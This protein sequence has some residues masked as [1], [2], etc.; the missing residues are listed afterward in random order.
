MAGWGTVVAE[1]RPREPDVE[2]RRRRNQVRISEHELVSC[3]GLRSGIDVGASAVGI[4]AESEVVPPSP[5]PHHPVLVARAPV[6]AIVELCV[7]AAVAGISGVVVVQPGLVGLIPKVAQR[8][9]RGVLQRSRDRVV[10]KPGAREV[11]RAGHRERIV[12]GPPHLREIALLLQR[13]R[14]VEQQ[15]TAL[16]LAIALIGGEEENAVLD[17]RAADIGAP[18]VLDERRCP[19]A[20]GVVEEGV[21][22]KNLVPQ[23]LVGR[24]MELVAAGLRGHV[25]DTAG[26]PSKLRTEVVGLDLEFLHG[27]L[28]RDQGGEVGVA[29]VDRRAVQRRGALIRLAATNLVV[30]PSEDVDPGGA[31]HGLPLRHD[32]R[33]KSDQVQHVAAVERRLGDLAGLDDLAKRGCLRLQQRRAGN[34]LNNL[35][36]FSDFQHRVDADARIDLDRDWLLRE[37]LEAI[38]ASFQAVLARNQVHEAIQAGRF[39]LLHA[40]FAGSEARH[41]DARSRNH[42]PCRVLNGPDQAA[43]EGLAKRATSDKRQARYQTSQSSKMDHVCPSTKHSSRLNS[44]EPQYASRAYRMVRSPATGHDDFL[45]RTFGTHVPRRPDHL[46]L[47]ARSPRG[48]TERRSA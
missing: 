7:V 11:A 43:I 47:S 30:A 46:T 21:G 32:T 33:S 18:L 2:N 40:L 48:R 38:R 39:R 29:D 41:G 22:I 25:D 3:E 26:E 35:G 31:L 12:D 27:V 14:R 16:P 28:G 23:E 45:W 17:D 8:P 4:D 42:G 24:A 6:H 19:D 10:L 36:D 44:S 20:A 15:R 9:R 37:L 34:D 1:T 13:G 5:A